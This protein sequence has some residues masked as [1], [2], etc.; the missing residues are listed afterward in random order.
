MDPG[1]FSVSMRSV[2]ATHVVVFYTK[3]FGTLAAEF[4]IL[5]FPVA[6]MRSVHPPSSLEGRENILIFQ[7]ITRFD[8]LFPGIIL[9]PIRLRRIFCICFLSASV[10][11]SNHS[12]SRIS[13]RLYRKNNWPPS[14]WATVL[15]EMAAFYTRGGLTLTIR[16]RAR[17]VG[18]SLSKNKK[19][20][21]FLF[22][23][24][25]HANSPESHST[26][27]LTSSLIV[28]LWPFLT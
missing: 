14:R 16:R 26:K 27:K 25:D 24:Y 28:G 19:P 7:L 1:G 3:C 22:L 11:L 9:S 8:L 12:W 10:F 17:V 18:R 23:L 2:R 13:H 20:G 6:R 5:A 21:G 4:V 15:L